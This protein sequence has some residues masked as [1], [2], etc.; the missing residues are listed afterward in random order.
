MG[1]AVGKG[2]RFVEGLAD[3]G[4]KPSGSAKIAKA[5]DAAL[6]WCEMFL[7]G[8][9]FYG[10]EGL[11][12]KGVEATIRNIARLEHDGMRETNG[13]IIKMMLASGGGAPG[14]GNPE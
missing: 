1:G 5:V 7:A 10:G 13:E 6:P 14:V 4:T 3:G 9:Q 11:V 8:K 2:K 12:T